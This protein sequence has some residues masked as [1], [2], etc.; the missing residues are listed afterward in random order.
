MSEPAKG[1][2]SVILLGLDDEVEALRVAKVIAS[3]TGRTVTVRDADGIE[4]ETVPPTNH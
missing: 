4:I 1:H 3:K 2:S